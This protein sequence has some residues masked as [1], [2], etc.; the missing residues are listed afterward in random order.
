MIINN[1]NVNMEIDT[2]A[3]IFIIGEIIW[4][5]IV[6]KNYR[7]QPAAW[8][9]REYSGTPVNVLGQANVYV[10]YVTFKGVLPLIISNGNI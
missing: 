3:G 8:K 10:H 4:R 1:H 7:L 9:H 2:D 6:S 5:L